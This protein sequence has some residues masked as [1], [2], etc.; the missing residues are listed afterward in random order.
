MRI[1][2]LCSGALVSCDHYGLEQIKAIL[3]SRL[4]MMCYHLVLKAKLAL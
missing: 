1:C 4:I 2:S 3:D